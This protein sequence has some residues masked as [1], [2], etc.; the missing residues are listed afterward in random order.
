MEHWKAKAFSIWCS[1]GHGKN[2]PLAH[3]LLLNSML[4]IS[5]KF[6][7]LTCLDC[8]IRLIPYGPGVPISLPPRNLET[9]ENSVSEKSLSDSQLTKCSEYEYDDD[10][11]P[12]P[13]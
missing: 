8:A 7:I 12:K 10:Q 9:V 4:K 5:I 2:A 6:N 13:F 11:Q 3:V 1:N